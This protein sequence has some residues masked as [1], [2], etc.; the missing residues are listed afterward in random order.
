M[1]EKALLYFFEQIKNVGLMY[2]LW[3]VILE[4]IILLL[5]I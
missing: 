2:F 3:K 5:I 1:W 4:I